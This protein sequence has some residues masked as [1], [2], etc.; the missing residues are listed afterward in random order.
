MWK[1]REESGGVTVTGTEF[2][3]DWEM[4]VE[5]GWMDGR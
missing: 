1:G 2:R 5:M 3:L 4:E